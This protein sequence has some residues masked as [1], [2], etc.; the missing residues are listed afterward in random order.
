MHIGNRALLC[1]L[2]RM[3]NH[4]YMTEIKCML[5]E[6]FRSCSPKFS[7][8]LCTGYSWCLPMSRTFSSLLI[9]GSSSGLLVMLWY[10]FQFFTAPPQ[11]ETMFLCGHLVNVK[12]CSL[13]DNLHKGRNC[14]LI[15]TI[16]LAPSTRCL[17]AFPGGLPEGL[18][19]HVETGFPSKKRW[20]IIF[21]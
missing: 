20:N 14:V 19:K 1:K 3:W 6:W 8:G 16:A 18:L 4:E 11:S 13:A 21:W 2:N 17:T 12:S 7:Q 15:I 5:G 10:D 9:C